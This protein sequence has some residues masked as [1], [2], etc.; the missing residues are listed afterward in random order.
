MQLR[1][2]KLDCLGTF[3]IY[4]IDVLNPYSSSSPLSL[5]LPCP[6]PSHPTPDKGNIAFIHP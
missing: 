4:L 6:P 3:F 5:P 1:T 2:S